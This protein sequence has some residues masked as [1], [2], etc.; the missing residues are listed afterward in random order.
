MRNWGPSSRRGRKPRKVSL[1]LGASFLSRRLLVLK[2]EAEKLSRASVN[3]AG[4]INT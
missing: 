1:T 4:E 3:R 2:A